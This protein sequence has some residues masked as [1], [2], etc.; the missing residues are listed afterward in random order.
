[1]FHHVFSCCLNR[2]LLD[3]THEKNKM[4]ME[5]FN[6]ILQTNPYIIIHE[7]IIRICVFTWQGL[8]P[9]FS[10]SYFQVDS[11]PA[12]SELYSPNEDLSGVCY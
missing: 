4:K 10:K 1:M 5:E 2:N 8:P 7:A 6:F 11:F 9:H 12:V 3:V